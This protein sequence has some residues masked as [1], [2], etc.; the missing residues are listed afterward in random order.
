MKNLQDFKKKISELR[1]VLKP[2]ISDNIQKIISFISNENPYKLLMAL[3][4]LEKK[5]SKKKKK[6][7][8]KN[9]L[10]KNY[11]DRT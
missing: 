7:L 8:K 6:S 4:R 1:K 10:K 5:K 9:N 11:Q 2:E 3:T